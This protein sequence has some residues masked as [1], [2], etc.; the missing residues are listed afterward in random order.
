[1]WYINWNVLFMKLLTV[2]SS[3]DPK[4][5]GISQGIRNNSPFWE[6]E[7]FSDTIVTLDDSNA[8]FVQNNNVIALGPGSNIWGYSEKF[9]NWI[10]DNISNYDAIVV[11]GLWLYN[12]YI[13]F[14]AIKA[15]KI[16]G[17]PI[18]KLFV[19]PHGML[20]PYFQKSNTRKLKA[21]RNIVYWHLIE[22]RL[23]KIA[24]AVLFTC[25]EEMRLA[26]TTFADYNPKKVFNIGFG[27]NTPPQLHA[28]QQIAFNTLTP[29]LHKVLPELGNQPYILF[30]GRIDPKKGVD[31]IIDAYATIK[32]KFWNDGNKLPKLVIAGPASDIAYMEALKLQVKNNP[33]LENA[34]LFTGMLQGDSKWG[35]LYG[36][37][38]FILPSH[39]EN[40]GIA[41]VEAMACS[42]PVLITNKVN[43]F[44][45]I[46]LGKGGIIENDDLAGTINLLTK[47]I[48]FNS[49]EKKE[50]GQ[51]AYEIYQSKFTAKNTNKQFVSVL[52]LYTNKMVS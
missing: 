39:Q 34:I 8:S 40:F 27:I 25:E 2:L 17:K 42:K 46:E 13:L 33:L 32:N 18:P 51:N 6:A 36:C 38:A 21:I 52:Q 31:L 14:K 5:G 26:A 16:A 11:H 50:M 37:E 4:A 48:S 12:N 45:E 9:K 47:W 10:F 15:L 29:Q 20:D 43:I 7:G 24:D 44:N 1:M 19:M 49:D 41:V 23:I 30:L 22:K 3:M 28:K 35:A